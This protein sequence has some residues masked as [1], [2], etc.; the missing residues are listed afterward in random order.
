MKRGEVVIVAT[1]GAYT[2]EPRQ[3]LVVQFGAFNDTHASV[4]ICPKT[5]LSI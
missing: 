1:R 4:T 5:W 2:N 3:A